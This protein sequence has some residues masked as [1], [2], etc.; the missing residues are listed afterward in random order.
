[1]GVDIGP[2]GST[3]TY[4]KYRSWTCMHI[5]ALVLALTLAL[6]PVGPIVNL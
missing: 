3:G 6:L 5:L 1:M 4:F 2:A